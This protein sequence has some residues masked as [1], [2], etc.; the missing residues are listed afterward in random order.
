MHYK[1]NSSYY[2]IMKKFYFVAC[3]VMGIVL[4]LFDDIFYSWVP[5]YRNQSNDRDHSVMGIVL[6]LFDDIVYFWVALYRIQINNRDHY[7]ET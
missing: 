2:L 5:L 6:L 3:T 7:I 4:F 1:S